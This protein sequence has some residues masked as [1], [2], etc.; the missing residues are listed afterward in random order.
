[1]ES[2]LIDATRRMLH[3]LACLPKNYVDAPFE[4][5]ALFSN[6]CNNFYLPLPVATYK[7]KL[8][9]LQ[10]NLAILVHSSFMYRSFLF[11]IFIPLK[12]PQR[13]L[14]VHD[15]LS[16]LIFWCQK[17]WMIRYGGHWQKRENWY[18]IGQKVMLFRKKNRDCDKHFSQIHIF[19]LIPS[20]G[21]KGY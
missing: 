12:V 13:L 15:T 8:F 20:L 5:G 6:N 17:V 14:K 4:K 21:S 1:M 19:H 16:N 2:T 11:A 9:L 18:Y 10:S 7:C 3:V